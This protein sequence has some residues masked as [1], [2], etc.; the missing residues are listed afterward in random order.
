[1]ASPLDRFR[2]APA[3]NT[4]AENAIELRSDSIVSWRSVADAFGDLGLSP[5]KLEQFARIEGS[6]EAPWDT[7]IQIMA[8]D[9]QTALERFASR[10][11]LPFDAEPRLEESAMR[12][13]ELV[14][15][16]LARSLSVAGI[17]SDGNVMTIAAGQP[18]QPSAFSMLEDLLDMPIELVLAPRAAVASLLNRG[19][20]Q[21]GDLV[22]EIVEE[23]P[24]D[25]SAIETA[26]GVIGKQTDLLALARQAPVIRLVNMIL[27]EALRRRASDI[28]VHPMENKLAIRLRVDGMLTDAFSP[29]L[30]LAAA[31][32]S[33]LKVMTDLDIANRHSPQDG[34][35][36]VRI[37]SKK[38]DI[39]L[40]VIPSIYGERIVLRLLD[41]ST[42]QLDLDQL[43]M[44]KP[45]QGQLMDIVDR[46]NGIV[47][48]TGPT[49]SG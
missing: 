11:G 27:F 40:S 22:E 15:P 6:D 26:A 10:C 23:M 34:Q 30:G 7:M 24:L 41:Q 35:T 20:E 31:I 5:E 39:R 44:S 1:M 32:S 36:T 16:D 46:P 8:S 33:R 19:Y 25:A 21:R 3:T 38:V 2:A 12:F 14:R 49:G 13:Y 4:N 48:V 18:M 28:H 9:E 42:T 45:M 37:G 17:A 29:P 47:L 43:G